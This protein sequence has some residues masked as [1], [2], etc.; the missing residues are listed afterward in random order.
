MA[1]ITV[2]NLT[3]SYGTSH[4]NI[5]ENVSFQ[6][7]TDWKL[8]FIGR[9]GR[10]KTT[11]LRLLMGE[12]PYS[13]SISAPMPFSRFPFSVER[14][15]RSSLEIFEELAPETGRWELRR[16]LSL[17][18]VPEEALDRP[19]ESLSGG[20]GAKLMLAALFLRK[21]HFL[22]LDEPTNHLDYLGNRAVAEYLR[23]KKGYILVSHN[24]TLLDRAADHMLSIN[25]ADIEI[26]RG[27]FSQWLANRER[28]DESEAARNARLEKDIS[29]LRSAARRA[30]D[31]SDRTEA[32]KKGTGV[33]D[34]G[35]VGH[36]SAKM[37]KRS[38][39]LERRQNEAIGQKS[40]LLRNVERQPPLK[41]T[42]LAYHSEVVARL[43]DVSVSYG[44]EPVFGAA[45]LTIRRGMRVAL[46]GKNGCGKSS[47]IRLMLG[48]DIPHSGRVEIGSGAVLSYVPQDTSWLRGGARE[49]AES[50]GAD[51]TLFLSVLRNLGFE[52]VQFEKDLSELSEGQKKKALIAKS[53]SEPAHLY[54]WDEPLNYIDIQSR[55]QIERLL[56]E[57]RPTLLF[58][59]HDEAFIRNVA[60]DEAVLARL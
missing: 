2:S 3:F 51:L 57:Y 19:F 20:E 30:S 15:Q 9:N 27:G 42:P 32:S 1:L 5:F 37:M 39:S 12:C 48:Q 44:G 38:K 26:C 17:L 23:S 50:A 4:D 8:G 41:L 22:L 56:V 59:E 16:E 47:L 28:R 18:E 24:R 6:F 60:T 52:R 40:Q 14:P 58:V 10:G 55:L 49:F 21:N 25:R 29:K 33:A 36:M 34:R 35:Y 45:S 7:D 53:L 43:T 31:W 11:F 46:K 54:L 13:G